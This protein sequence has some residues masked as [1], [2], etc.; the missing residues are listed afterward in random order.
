MR[1][2]EVRG[3]H[4]LQPMR[5]GKRLHV[6]FAAGGRRVHTGEAAARLL[7]RGKDVA[8]RALGRR[9]RGVRDQLNIVVLKGG[10]STRLICC[11]T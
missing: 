3:P 4:Q 7:E 6:E 1:R 9:G 8:V 10:Q 2:L 11:V 5:L